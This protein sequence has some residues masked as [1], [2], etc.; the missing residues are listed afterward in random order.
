VREEKPIKTSSPGLSNPHRRKESAHKIRSKKVMQGTVGGARGSKITTRQQPDGSVARTLKLREGRWA[1]AGPSREGRS[2][3]YY[4]RAAIIARLAGREPIPAQQNASNT[5]APRQAGA[6]TQEGR[7]EEEM[8]EI[9]GKTRESL[10]RLEHDSAKLR[11]LREIKKRKT[12]SS[13]RRP[14]EYK[15]KKAKKRGRN[16]GKK[17]AFAST[18][19]LAYHYPL[20]RN[21]SLL[22]LQR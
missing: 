15:R 12:S 13:L 6:T 7:D 1:Y 21:D 2:G 5:S 3:W 10:R 14:A 11:S 19:T 22:F 18:R 4:R 9:R 16:G 8:K 17:R 20:P